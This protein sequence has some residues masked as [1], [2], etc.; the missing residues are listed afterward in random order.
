MKRRSQNILQVRLCV[1][2]ACFKR[3]HNC[4]FGAFGSFG[5]KL[6]GIRGRWFRSSKIFSKKMYNLNKNGKFTKSEHPSEYWW[7]IRN[8]YGCSFSQRAQWQGKVDHILKIISLHLILVFCRNKRYISFHEAG[9]MML[10][11]KSLLC[12]WVIV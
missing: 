8:I 11:L 10:K 3:H 12:N 2:F 4:Y 7:L 6:F 5:W 9:L 1:T